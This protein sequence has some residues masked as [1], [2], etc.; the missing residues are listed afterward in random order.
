[1][2]QPFRVTSF[3]SPGLRVG[4]NISAVD[5]SLVRDKFALT[6]EDR[7]GNI[8]MLEHIDH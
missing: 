2:G 1:V 6:M 7:V 8:W 4:D 3:D 5:F